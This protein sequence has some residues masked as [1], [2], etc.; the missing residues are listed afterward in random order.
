MGAV[1]NEHE[2][3]VGFLINNDA[4]INLKD[5]FGNTALTYA[6]E[7][8]NLGIACKLIDAGAKL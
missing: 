1:E 7:K 3:I 5:G 8:E 4:D 2:N 6:I